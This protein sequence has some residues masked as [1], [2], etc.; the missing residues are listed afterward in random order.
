MNNFVEIPANT[1]SLN[2]RKPIYGVGINDSKY[3]TQVTSPSGST[4]VC[5][6]YLKWK[7]MI[8]RC[9][10]PNR[11]VCHQTY[12]D[13]TVCSEWLV[14]SS[15]KAW[16]KTQDW[17][18]KQLDKDLL[19]PGN[20][21]YGPQSCIFVEGRI[22]FL[23]TDSRSSKGEFQTGVTKNKGRFKARCCKVNGSRYSGSYSTEAEARAA[24]CKDKAKQ[25][26]N[27]AFSVI[28]EDSLYLSLMIH[29]LIFEL[30]HL[31]ISSAY[32]YQG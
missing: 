23:L 5:P 13:C 32:D 10:N 14:F 2:L 7:A 1:T 22:N 25:C 8:A 4:S 6:Y 17:N 24:Y 11:N 20:K 19:I 21:E 31:E 9:Y 12:S 30:E 3:F 18:G 27:I 28:S 26:R 29:A 16:M 15:F